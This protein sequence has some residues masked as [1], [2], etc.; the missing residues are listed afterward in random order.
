MRDERFPHFENDEHFV[1]IN[2]G[3]ADDAAL[4]A[5]LDV[6]DDLARHFQVVAAH[7]FS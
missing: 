6:A 5:A 1:N 2:L 4:D 3:E 7:D